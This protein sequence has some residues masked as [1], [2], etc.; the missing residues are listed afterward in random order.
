MPGPSCGTE[1]R[2]SLGGKRRPQSEV[3]KDALDDSRVRVLVVIRPIKLE[4]H[5]F[6]GGA[7][8]KGGSPVIHWQ[9]ANLS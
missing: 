7:F 1:R 5:W 9:P 2:T 4:R 6:K 8:T 3:L